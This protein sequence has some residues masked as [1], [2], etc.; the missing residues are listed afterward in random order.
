MLGFAKINMERSIKFTKR[1]IKKYYIEI[2]VYYWLWSSIF[3]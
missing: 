2:P 1:R 3:M